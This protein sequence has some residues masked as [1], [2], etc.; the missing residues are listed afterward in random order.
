MVYWFLSPGLA[1]YLASVVRYF[2]SG[3]EWSLDPLQNP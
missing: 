2:A 1:E 3:L